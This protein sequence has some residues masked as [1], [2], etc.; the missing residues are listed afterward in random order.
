MSRVSRRELL[1]AAA[2]VGAAGA[3]GVHRFAPGR[4]R[5]PQVLVYDSRRP[6]SLAFGQGWAGL[7]RIDLAR[8]QGDNW[9]AIRA[10]DRSR[11]VA[12]LTGW[13]DYV[14]AR[15]WLEERGLRLVEEMHDRRSDLTRWVMA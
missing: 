14:F 13:N 4:R 15:Q 1:G 11:V 2:L 8:E 12:G 9:R 3:V 10:L 5:A 7:R 6:A